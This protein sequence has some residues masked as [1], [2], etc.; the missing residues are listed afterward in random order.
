MIPIT[1]S[2]FVCLYLA[3]FLTGILILWIGYELICKRHANDI[4]RDRIFCRICGSRYTDISTR[5]L[6]HCPVCD[7]LNERPSLGKKPRR[8]I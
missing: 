4:A 8:A 7:S 1:L 2:W 6:L 5:D 3:L